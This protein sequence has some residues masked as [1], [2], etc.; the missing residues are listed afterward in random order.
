MSQLRRSPTLS[1]LATLRMALASLFA[2]LLAVPLACAASSSGGPGGAT[3]GGAS[4]AGATS[5]GGSNSGGSGGFLDGGGDAPVIDEDSACLV[6]RIRG[7]PIPAVVLFQLDTSGSMNCDVNNPGC[8]AGD[9]TP[10]PNDS[11]WD[12]FRA[13]LSQSLPALP[14]SAQVGLMNFPTTFS[15][16]QNSPVVDFTPIASAQTSIPAALN[17]LTPQGITPTHDAVL[18]GFLRLE[19]SALAGNRFLVLATDGQ[20]T[21][22]AGCDAACSFAALAQDDQQMVADIAARAAQGLKTFVIGVQGSSSY[23]NILS[24]MASASGTQIP[25]CSD[26]GPV[27]CHY[28]LTDPNLDFA[29]SLAD[30][31][32][33]VAGSISS[34]EFSI[35]DSS[36]GSF[37]PGKVNVEVD[38]GAGPTAVKR[39]PSRQDGWDYSDDDTQIVLYGPSCEA[40]KAATTAQVNL[41]F[42]CPTVIK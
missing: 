33:D 2:C 42:G 8:L 5:A 22:C 25:G 28:D 41:L 10:A 9:P 19:G 7:E 21:V 40:A 17:Q 36:G 15:C 31:L 20:S 16:S 27:Y 32:T 38:T 3:N 24:R 23:R 26:N 34:C 13:T 4:G 37:D 6:D 12:L 30:A 1:E 35:P 18:N 39:D 11:R 14:A 29:Q